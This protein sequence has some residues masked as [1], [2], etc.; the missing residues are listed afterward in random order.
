VKCLNCGELVSSE[1]H[2]AVQEILDEDSE[3]DV[4][5][6]PS[7]IVNVL[8]LIHCS[9]P[10]ENFDAEGRV[11]LCMGCVEGAQCDSVT[12]DDATEL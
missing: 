5:G 10:P 1:T 11:V 6:D 2:E 3:K 7:S 4:R 9:G 12:L 8:G